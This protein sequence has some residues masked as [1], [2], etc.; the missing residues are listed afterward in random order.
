MLAKGKFSGGGKD[1]NQWKSILT[2][3]LVSS[4]ESDEEN[5][6]EVLIAHPLPWLSETVAHFKMSLDQ[7]IA[8]SK[9]PQARRQ[10]KKRLIGGSS[11]RG[12]LDD[13]PSWAVKQ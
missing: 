10:M 12:A 4:D 5:G 1:L 3:D 6:E 7:Q 9:S 2:M 11:T 8:N 13:L